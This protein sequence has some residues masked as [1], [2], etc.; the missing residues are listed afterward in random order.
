VRTRPASE[1]HRA[2]RGRL[3]FLF[4]TI[5]NEIFET[6]LLQVQYK[7]GMHEQCHLPLQEWLHKEKLKQR[8]NFGVAF[9]DLHV[10]GFTTPEQHQPTVSSCLFE[11]PRTIVSIFSN[12]YHKQTGILHSCSGIVEPGEMLLVLGRPGSGCSTFLKTLAGD[13]S[14]IYLRDSASINYTGKCTFCNP[15]RNLRSHYTNNAKHVAGIS[16][17]S[18]HRTLR[19]KCIYTAELDYHFP[20]MTTGQTL[21]FSAEMRFNNLI[22][23]QSPRSTAQ[24]VA[25]FFNL[26]SAFD[27]KVGNAMMR[28]ISGG[29]IKRASIAEAFINDSQLQCWDNSTRGLDSSTALRFAML[30]RA[31]TKHLGTAVLTSIYQASEKIYC[32]RFISYSKEEADD[33][34]TFDKV[35]LFY[36]GHQ[37]YFGS[38]SSAPDYFMEMGFEKPSGATTADFLTSITN[39][40]ERKARTGWENR[41]PRTAPEFFQHWVQ[42]AEYASL[43]RSIDRFNITNL[44]GSSQIR[45]FESYSISPLLQTRA[46]VMRGFLRLRNNVGPGVAGIIGNTIIAIV[47]GSVFYDLPDTTA[48]FQQR[49]I[50]LFFVVMMNGCTPAFEVIKLLF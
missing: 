3:L 17:D 4:I 23:L 13:T 21:A 11:I 35:I 24:T 40:S 5:V 18:M 16:Y 38:V 22:P 30:L 1:P 32:V 37:I 46:C 6:I 20:E 41:V 25:G 9:K 19:G 43:S 26:G 8:I 49:S 42:S 15:S 2:T 12:R 10:Y 34:Q 39:P 29:E 28:G 14:G 7:M 33:I 31:T 47:T 36:E 50:L 48:S 27:T 45:N 44:S